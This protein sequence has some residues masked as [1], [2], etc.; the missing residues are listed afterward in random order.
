MTLG[1]E[2]HTHSAEPAGYLEKAIRGRE[3]A[4]EQ[5]NP[6]RP[7]QAGHSHLRTEDGSVNRAAL[8]LHLR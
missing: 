3:Q 6:A 1:E 7:T 5:E 4:K 8:P 2:L